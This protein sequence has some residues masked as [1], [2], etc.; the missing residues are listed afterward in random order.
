MKFYQQPEI[1]FEGISL[2]DIM[3]VSFLSALNEGDNGSGISDRLAWGDVNN[4]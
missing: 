3:T 1:L 2:A 4:I